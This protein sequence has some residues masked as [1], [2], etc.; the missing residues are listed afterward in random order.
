MEEFK[1][2][3]KVVNL[4]KVWRIMGEEVID[5]G[6]R[7][8]KDKKWKGKKEVGSKRK[9]EDFSIIEKKRIGIE[10]ERGCVKEEKRIYIENELKFKIIG[11]KERKMDGI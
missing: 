7:R 8:N 5:E 9:K 11:K 1:E 4:D 3:R 2:F 10:E 6:R